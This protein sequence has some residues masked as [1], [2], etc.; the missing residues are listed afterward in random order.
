MG[1]RPANLPNERIIKGADFEPTYELRDADGELIDLT[2][3]SVT[4]VFYRVLP[5][6]ASDAVVVR[7]K[8]EGSSSL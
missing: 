2:H 7:K 5:N 8:T 6:G 1:V 3:V 4:D